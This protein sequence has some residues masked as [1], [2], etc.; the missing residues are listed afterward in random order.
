[1]AFLVA[2]APTGSGE[3]WFPQADK[4]RHA[5]AFLVLWVLGQQA[6]VRPGW[7]LAVLLLGFGVAI[8]LAQ[9]LTSYRDASLGDVGADMAGIVAG[10]LLKPAG[11][12]Q[13]PSI[14]PRD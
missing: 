1:M 10:W 8:E 3:D 14:S 11:P 13:P 6:R 9:G 12:A 4:L 7:R 5:C 2:L